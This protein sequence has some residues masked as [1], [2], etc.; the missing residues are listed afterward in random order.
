MTRL[1]TRQGASGEL[2]LGKHRIDGHVWLAPMAGVTDRPFRI[3]C[4]SLGAAAAVAEMLSSD[5]RLWRS[6]KSQLRMDHAGEPSPRI[7]Q[8]AGA[9]PTQMA[10]AARANV[11]LGAEVIDI[12]MGCPAKKVCNR[13]CGSALLRE[14]ELAL[15]IIAAVVGAVDVPVTLKMRTGWDVAS[16]NAVEVATRAAQAGIAMIAVH[17]RT[18]CD[19]YQG[20]AEH[21]TAA[22]LRAS[23]DIPVIANGD[24]T[25]GAVAQDVIAR[26]GANAVMIGRAAHGQPW[27]F[28]DVNS[29]LATNSTAHSLSRK[30]KHD[31]ILR[32]LES[33]YAFHG[34]AGGLRIA[35]KHLNWYCQSLQAAS[36][37]RSALLAC[38]TTA[39]QFKCA[40]RL[41]DT[42]SGQ[43]SEAA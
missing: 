27:I 22:R 28:R 33:I 20:N 40:Q 36:L 6:R 10:L 35:R 30:Y 14:P 11:D 9:D 34:E 3:L 41:L 39:E 21:D 24:I 2:R 43:D 25:N 12:N 15:R 38:A 26:S 4:R 8:L 16:R 29:H 32:H 7:V 17:G 37:L 1:N 5:Q 19:F 42:R 23:L 18:R 31:I 13:A